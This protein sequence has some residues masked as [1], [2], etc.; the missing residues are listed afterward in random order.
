[1]TSTKQ[2]NRISKFLSLILRHNPEAI[3]IKLDSNGWANIEEIITKTNKIRHNEFRTLHSSLIKEVVRKNDKKRF[4]VSTDEKYI[5]ANQGH[6]LHVDL[7]LQPTSPPEV[8]YHGTASRFLTSITKHGL[9]PQ[10]RQHVHLSTD[11]D[12]AI[13]VGQRYGKPIVLRVKAQLMSKQGFEFYQAKNNVWLTNSVP[14]KFIS[15]FSS[16]AS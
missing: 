13:A 15:I 3:G 9:K 2:L 1:M 16:H 11:V 6:S 7:Q 8:L 12:A 5:R 14:E 10:Q 4:S